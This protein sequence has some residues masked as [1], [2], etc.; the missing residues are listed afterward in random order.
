IGKELGRHHSTVAR[1][2]KR[3][4]V[5]A[6]YCSTDAHKHYS[7]RR[8]HCKSKG[9]WTESLARE[10]EQKLKETWSPEQIVGRT[11][12]GQLSFKTIY[13]W[14]YK[15]LLAKGNLTL[16]RQKGKRRKPKET[17]GRFNV[18]RSIHERPDNVRTREVFGDWELDTVLSG[19]GKSKGC[20]A[21]FV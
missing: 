5:E 7:K 3:N 13:R 12:P 14:L 19:R 21:T 10:I 6:T 15:G 18:G 11:L 16:L 1:E 20:F 17:R 8:K 2:I 9:K 4:K